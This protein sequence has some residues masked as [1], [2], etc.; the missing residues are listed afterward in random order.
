M[1]GLESAKDIKLVQQ[2]GTTHLVGEILFEAGDDG[3][4]YQIAWRNDAFSG[5]FLSMRPF[6]CIVG[7][8]KHWCRLP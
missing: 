8:S 2:D 1:E 7:Q 6:K 4:R 3:A 5:H